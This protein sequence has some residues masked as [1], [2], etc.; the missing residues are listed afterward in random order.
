MK[1][2]KVILLTT[3]SVVAVG[4]LLTLLASG[5]LVSS[6]TMSSSGIIATAN[7][8]VYSDSACTQK[9]TSIDWGTI[10]PGGS[11][12]KTVYVK[13]IGTTQVNLSL[14]STGWNPSNTNGP[15]TL[16]WNSEGTILATN[17]VTTATLTLTVSS[18]INGITNFNVNIVVA[19]TG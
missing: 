6:T 16:T 8:G 4:L 1:L 18:T 12:T 7:L 13:N 14:T 2:K 5:A 19:G 11:V 17:Q 15:I 9:I 3:A 10:S